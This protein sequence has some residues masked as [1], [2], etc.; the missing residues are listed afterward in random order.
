MSLYY[1][2]FKIHHNPV[3]P[4][5]YNNVK[6]VGISNATSSSFE[7]YHWSQQS[8]HHSPGGH[9]GQASHSSP[10]STPA[11]PA[12][13]P[14]V[15]IGGGLP[16]ATTSPPLSAPATTGHY[17]FDQDA[18]NN[19]LPHQ[20]QEQQHLSQL[21]AAVPHQFHQLNAA[22][23]FITTS[24]HRFQA[25]Q[26]GPSQNF[27]VPN[28]NQ[29]FAFEAAAANGMMGAQSGVSPNS[30]ALGNAFSGSDAR[31]CV[32]CGKWTTCI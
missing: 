23:R 24:T 13:A 21:V 26:S 31:E 11:S 7:A 8:Q 25:P 32:N 30:A 10:T 9:N 19:N 20:P 28:G 6:P 18:L 2:I 22:H 27:V 3:Y 1:F 12:S 4:P 5:W 14:V 29:M 16:P 17:F 15:T